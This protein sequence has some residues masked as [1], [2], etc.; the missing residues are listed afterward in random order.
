ME[1][2]RARG[3][4]I[5]AARLAQLLAGM[6]TARPAYRHLAA[7]VRTLILDG[8]IA[9]DARL[10]A[11]RELAPALALS[12][13][14][15]S[16]AYEQLRK[17]GYARSR[18]GSGTWTALPESA[19]CPAQWDAMAPGPPH[20]ATP[21]MPPPGAIDIATAA[22]PMPQDV[23][24]QDLAE[25]VRHLPHPAHTS[26][27]H[28]YGL[29]ELRTAVAARYT[30]R[31]L[32]THREQILVTAGAQQALSL[33]LSLLCGPGDR[34][35]VESPSYPNAL[36]AIRRARLHPV[37]VPVTEDGWDGDLLTCALRQ[38]V[39][40]LAYLIPAFHNPTGALMPPGQCA[41]VLGATRRPGTWLVV[42]ETLADMALDTATPTP[43]AAHGAGGG[44]EHV[45][46][47]GS[48]SK[49]Y[50]SGL[51]VGWLRA[52]PRLVAELAEL[53]ATVDVSGSVLD[54]LLALLLLDRGDGWLA[55]RVDQVRHRRQTLLAALERYLP[56]WSW[57]LPPGGLS[58]WVDLG[59]PVASALAERALAH[60]V[61]IGSGARFGGEPGLYEHRLRIPY[62]LPPAAL[63][64]A[65]RR[66]A[67]VLAD[68]PPV[69]GAAR[70]RS[71]WVA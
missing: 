21:P 18:R 14:T 10:P 55:D 12:R 67:A 3:A 69:A 35:L 65:V 41:E 42:D 6:T 4:A 5:P 70:S 1:Q 43:F 28:S 71:D 47:I 59:Q 46:S 33:A 50:W 7:A 56:H 44:G 13:T 20:G 8:G 64:E 22:L 11:E 45:I 63:Q 24:H 19:H 54:Q 40:R 61:R 32:P 60:G 39:P 9:V 2:Q 58:L 48:L 34:V 38:S 16:A 51:R 57:R 37:P 29:P 15:I 27:Y 49:S 26:G 68:W 23:L 30:A 53:R 66:L 62:T 52:S 31:G 36:D 25:A 17:N